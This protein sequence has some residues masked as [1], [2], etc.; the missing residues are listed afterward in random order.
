MCSLEVR[1]LKLSIYH[2]N[3]PVHFREGVKC[4]DRQKWFCKGLN[5]VSRTVLSP[6]Y[7]DKDI[8]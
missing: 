3:K 6:D 5:W 2:E 4:Q 7:D 8:F 1:D